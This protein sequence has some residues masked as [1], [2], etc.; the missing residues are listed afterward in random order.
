MSQKILKP[1]GFEIL[2]TA[3]S[4]PYGGKISFTRTGKRWS[5]QYHD[6]KTET[7]VLLSGQANLS[8]GP[9][10]NSL[11]TLPME[12]SQE[13]TIKPSTIHR[14]QAVTDCVTV[15]FS[16]PEIGTTFR[17]E[18][19]YSRPNESDATRLLPGRGWQPLK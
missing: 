17:L 11:V 6:Q 14:F 4:L 9:D 18:D 8:L 19:D 12:P 3:A 10:Q 13:Y 1:W 2:V 15:E 5:L 16:T 7:L